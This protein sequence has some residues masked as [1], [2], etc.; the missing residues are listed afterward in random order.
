[1]L[2][3]SIYP[4][5]HQSFFSAGL[6]FGASN[7]AFAAGASDRDAESVYLCVDSLT[8]WEGLRNIF[9]RL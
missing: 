3:L 1:M 5:A 4:A 8:V 7:V 9:G 2:Y 6:D